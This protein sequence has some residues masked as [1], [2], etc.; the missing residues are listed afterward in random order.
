MKLILSAFIPIIYDLTIILMPILHNPYARVVRIFPLLQ[1]DP[2][3]NLIMV[4]ISSWW[5]SKEGDFFMISLCSAFGNLIQTLWWNLGRL[6]YLG[7]V[8]GCASTKSYI[9]VNED[10]SVLALFRLD[11]ARK[12]TLSQKLQ[13]YNINHRWVFWVMYKHKYTTSQ[14]PPL[15]NTRPK[16]HSS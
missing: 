7:A 14:L 8:D 1:W 2:R 9:T 6:K 15:T 4:G 12:C 11:Q 16:R 13:R 10:L 3:L 5:M